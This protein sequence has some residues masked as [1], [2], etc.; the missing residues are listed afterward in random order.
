MFVIHWLLQNGV[1]QNITAS[2]LLAVPTLVVG[3]RKLM[4]RIREH[5][6][7]V[8]EMHARLTRERRPEPESL[9]D[10]PLFRR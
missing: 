6:R 1:G 9:D 10:Y 8:H 5:E 3:W 4:P 7:K 2:A